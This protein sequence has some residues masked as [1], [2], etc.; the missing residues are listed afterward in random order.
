MM[1]NVF[2]DGQQV[3]I[4]VP[5][6]VYLEQ[7]VNFTNLERLWEKALIPSELPTSEALCHK[8]A[9][10]LLTAIASNKTLEMVQL[11][12]Y[13]LSRKPGVIGLRLTSAAANADQ[14]CE[15]IMGTLQ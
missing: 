11:A 10:L 15:F 7:G 5:R 3:P 4:H 8:A 2:L 12:G 9:E 14:R 1:L 13:I 6:E